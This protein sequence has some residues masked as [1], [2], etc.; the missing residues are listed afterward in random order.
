MI[1]PQTE[2]GPINICHCLLLSIMYD[3]SLTSD[4]KDALTKYL[5]N[6]VMPHSTSIPKTYEQIYTDMELLKLAE[7][8]KDCIEKIQSLDDLFDFFFHKL[9]EIRPMDSSNSNIENGSILDLYLRRSLLSFNKLDF[10][11]LTKF[12]SEFVG[13]VVTQSTSKETAPK[14][15]ST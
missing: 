7:Y 14:R 1:Q 6:E 13:S 9:K 3:Q 11:G 8:F 4:Q 10:S 5:V 15:G 12:Y 2:I